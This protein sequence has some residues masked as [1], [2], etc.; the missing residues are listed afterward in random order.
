M[1]ERLAST[2]HQACFS[3]AEVECQCYFHEES[4]HCGFVPPGKPGACCSSRDVQLSTALQQITLLV[5]AFDTLGFYYW[6]HLEG[7]AF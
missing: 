4:E 1:Q 3:K 6:G 7:G 2:W 5:R